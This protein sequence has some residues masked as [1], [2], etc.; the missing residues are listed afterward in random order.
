MRAS[1]VFMI[2]AVT[3]TALVPPPPHNQPTARVNNEPRSLPVAPALVG[4]IAY[5]PAQFVF[6]T[7]GAWVRYDDTARTLHVA[8]Q[9]KALHVQRA[10]DAVRLVVDATGPLRAETHTLV[11][12]DRLVVDLHGGGFCPPHP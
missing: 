7:L 11:N 5:V 12:P 3:A 4:E 2:V 9:I 10:G 6:S 1:V 8:S